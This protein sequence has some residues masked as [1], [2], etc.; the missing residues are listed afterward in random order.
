MEGAA[1]V[2]AELGGRSQTNVKVG[3]RGAGT[4]GLGPRG[5][6]R[7][8]VWGRSGEGHGEWRKWKWRKG[9]EGAAAPPRGAHRHER[10]P[11]GGATPRPSCRCWET[12]KEQTQRE[13]EL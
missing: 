4:R 2:G 8:G 12:I 3:S 6:R 10:G 5:V 7:E 11:A 13:R 1:G 9:K